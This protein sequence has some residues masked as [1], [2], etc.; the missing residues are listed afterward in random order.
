MNTTR[1]K[2]FE[3]L[4]DAVNC[5]PQE[6]GS[7]P[8]N[9]KQGRQNLRSQDMELEH[10]NHGLHPFRLKR[11]S[12]TVWKISCTGPETWTPA[13]AGNENSRSSSL[14]AK[15]SEGQL[16]RHHLHLLHFW[17]PTSTFRGGMT[18]CCA[19]GAVTGSSGS[20]CFDE[21]YAAPQLPGFKFSSEPAIASLSCA[22][23]SE[24]TSYKKVQQMTSNQA[25]LKR[26]KSVF[27]H[28]RQSCQPTCVMSIAN[29]QY[30][31][32]VNNHHVGLVNFLKGCATFAA[33]AKDSKVDGWA[34]GRFLDSL[35]DTKNY[36][37]AQRGEV[38]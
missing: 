18:T 6:W 8:V 33:W 15:G 32:V 29:D 34:F 13:F 38:C 23:L 1:S 21:V 2:L 12:K 30:I 35:A 16:S 10:T 19:E 17:R 22:S 37:P 11:S 5:P 27:E 24:P 36:S 20:C 26:Q 9:S 7:W 31:L 14:L 3:L 28:L 4:D 25:W